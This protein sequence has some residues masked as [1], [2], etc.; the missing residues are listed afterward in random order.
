MHLKQ[1]KGKITKS[2]LWFFVDVE[3]TGYLKSIFLLLCFTPGSIMDICQSWESKNTSLGAL[4][5]PHPP[6]I[7]SPALGLSSYVAW[8]KSHDPR[9]SVSSSGNRDDKIAA[10][11]RW[12]N[13]YEVLSTALDNGKVL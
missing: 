6:G 1:L 13:A 9:I 10:W 2:Q 11:I 12:D 4:T 8:G 3:I 5:H 7:L